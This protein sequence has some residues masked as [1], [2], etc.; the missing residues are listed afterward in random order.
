MKEPLK[1]NDRVEMHSTTSTELDGKHGSLMG[2]ASQDYNNTFW[3]VELDEPLAD[4]RAIVLSNSC[5]KPLIFPDVLTFS[6]HGGFPMNA[7]LDSVKQQVTAYIDDLVAR[8]VIYANIQGFDST[9]Y[10]I[11]DGYKLTRISD[12]EDIFRITVYGNGE[13]EFY[14]DSDD[15]MVVLSDGYGLENLSDIQVENV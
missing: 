7:S 11:S 3:I 10:E 13:V 6:L 4:R 8:G 9:D 15:E 14:A 2:I 12:G 5:L 1:F